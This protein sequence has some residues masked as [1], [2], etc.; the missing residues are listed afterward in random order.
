M[1]LINYLESF[2]KNNLLKLEDF[3]DLYYINNITLKE[4][5][6]IK[7][8]LN[9]YSIIDF[10]KLSR[11]YRDI[12]STIRKINPFVIT[13][14]G[15]VDLNNMKKNYYNSKIKGIIIFKKI[16]N[17]KNVKK[18]YNK[19]SDLNNDNLCLIKKDDFICLYD[20][21][22][23]KDGSNINLNAIL[24]MSTFRDGSNPYDATMIIGMASNPIFNA[25]DLAYP[26]VCYFN[27]RGL[28][29]PYR[30]GIAPSNLSTGARTVWYQFYTK[31][32]SPLRP[33]APIDDRDNPITDVKIDD[34]EVYNSVSR[35]KISQ[36]K[37]QKQNII[38][39][40]DQSNFLK[41]AKQGDF[42]DWVYQINPNIKS[43]IGYV[44]EKLILNHF[45]SEQDSISLVN[46][47][48]EITNVANDFF[49]KM[50][51]E[52]V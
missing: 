18:V 52:R 5:D 10:T 28:L 23:I 3:D 13:K 30:D 43:K 31:K 27:D 12:E 11:E 2:E 8:R 15:I 47:V 42:T 44:T 20:N 4:L 37:M 50:I 32:S 34:G 35:D 38:Q 29:F 21:S 26:I 19:I 45:K 24:F 22:I 41:K 14:R 48:K 51:K 36:W 39:Y 7:V 46:K 9:N 49:H 1:K 17:K 16:E 40:K 6:Y 25:K 33:Y